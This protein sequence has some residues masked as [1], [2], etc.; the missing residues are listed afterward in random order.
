MPSGKSDV[1]NLLAASS[2]GSLGTLLPH[3]LYS[4]AGTIAP[5]DELPNATQSD[6]YAEL[7]VVAMRLDPCFA[8]LA[9]DPHGAGCAAQLRLILQVIN[10]QE[11]DDGGDVIGA[12]DSAVHV[13]YSLTRDQLLT[14][15][16]ALVA[17]RTEQANGVA[18]G[19]LAPHP[20]IADQGLGGAMSQGVQSLILQFAGEQNITRVAEFAFAGAFLAWGFEA[21]DVTDATKPVTSEFA[22]PTLGLNDD[23][24]PVSSEELTNGGVND[25]TTDPSSVPPFIAMLSPVTSSSDNLTPLLSGMT[26]SLSSADLTAAFDALVRIENPTLNS[27]TTIDCASC[28]MATP[29]E[30][31]VVMPNFGL[32]DTTSALS[33]RPSGTSVTAADLTATFAPVNG[34]VDL[35]AF[36]YVSSTPAINQRVVNETASVVEYLNALP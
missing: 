3:A 5:I 17:L 23:G 27:P 7:H 13:F 22:I 8:A 24:S 16:Q 30:K 25:N 18:L 1:G 21:V 33:F 32:D 12:F 26:S 31:L 34:R 2:S 9:P 10:D 19:A 35:H 36:S 4:Q 14:L 28:H 20:I 6:D 29:T 11:G 15:A